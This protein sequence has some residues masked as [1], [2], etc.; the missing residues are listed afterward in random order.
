MLLTLVNC[1]NSKI[2]SD[3]DVADST[4]REEVA[5]A[6]SDTEAAS[7]DEQ[8]PD[9]EMLKTRIR[10]IFKKLPF[11]VDK[12]GVKSIFSK[13]FADAYL[14]AVNRVKKLERE[15][16]DNYSG[17]EAMMDGG[18]LDCWYGG[19]DPDP[20]GKITSF[21]FTEIT[22]TKVEATVKRT[23]ASNPKTFKIMLVKENGQWVLDDYDYCG[24]RDGWYKSTFE[25]YRR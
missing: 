10:E 1:G 25:N 16:G 11:D 24:V 5:I 22:P 12:S 3:T 7:V 17:D 23:N 19:Q 21:K 20:D 2:K 8:L 18:M 14:G 13:S 9:Q 6:D 15:L 4:V